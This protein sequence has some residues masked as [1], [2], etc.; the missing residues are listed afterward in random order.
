MLGHQ[1]TFYVGTS[2][3]TSRTIVTDSYIEGDIDFVFGSGSVVFDSVTFYVKGDRRTDEAVIFVPDTPASH[4]YGFLVID[5]TIEGA[6]NW[7]SSKTAYLARSWD[8]NVSSASDYVAGTS[9]NGQ[10]VIRET[11][12]SE[13]VKTSA[14]YTAAT[15]GRAYSGN[16]SSSRN[17]N[18][19]NYNRFWEYA[20]TGSGA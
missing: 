8:A 1:D 15:S 2:S 20:N 9:P 12:I 11:S 5:S 13:I 6:S 16:V 10:V 17:L 7:A 19:Q 4:E 18:N 14:P 3:S